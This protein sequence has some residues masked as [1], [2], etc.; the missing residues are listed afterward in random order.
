MPTVYLQSR[1]N[2][3][4]RKIEATDLTWVFGRLVQMLVSVLTDSA[5]VKFT[6]IQQV[7]ETAPGATEEA[8]TETEI[9]LPTADGLEVLQVTTYDYMRFTGTGLPAAGIIVS[10]S[11][12]VIAQAEDAPSD[13]DPSF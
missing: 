7:Q 5:S 9:A 12:Y 11:D 6:T 8:T 13:Y 10:L 2:R 1:T 4:P 3:P